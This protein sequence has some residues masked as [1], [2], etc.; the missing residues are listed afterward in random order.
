MKEGRKKERRKGG[1]NKEKKGEREES[2][3]GK[4]EKKDLYLYFWFWNDHTYSQGGVSVPII[5]FLTSKTKCGYELLKAA[6]FHSK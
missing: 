5:T 1:R 6:V 3:G 2:K 4:E